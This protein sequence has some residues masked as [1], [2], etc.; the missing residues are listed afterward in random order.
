M[1]YVCVLYETSNIFWFQEET[2]P[3]VFVCCFWYL[4]TVLLF[5]SRP[6]DT[7]PLENA[8]EKGRSLPHAFVIGFENVVLMKA[9]ILLFRI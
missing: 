2:P 4:T 7:E 3:G 5:Q 8:A 9:L 1:K 6:A